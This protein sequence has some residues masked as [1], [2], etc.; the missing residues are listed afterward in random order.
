[1]R[2]PLRTTAS[3]ATPG[4][5]LST[6]APGRADLTAASRHAP[7]DHAHLRASSAR[8]IALPARAAGAARPGRCA[9]SCWGSSTAVYTIPSLALFS[10]LLPFTGLSQKTVVIG[11]VL[12][13]LTV[14]VR[15]VLTGLD[16]VPEEV[17]D[18][19]RGM[20]FAPARAA[21]A[22]RAAA[23]AARRALRPAG[24]DRL[25]RRADDGRHDRRQRR[26]RRPRSTTA[27]GTD[28][29]AEVLTA[30]VLCVVL[31]L[32]LDAVLLVAARLLVP[33]RRR[34]ARGG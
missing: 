29:N 22:G 12:Y 27:C 3:F 30:S 18:A 26:P 21:L 13:S 5:A 33:W 25:D 7:A 24:R 15:T 28:F 23:G 17:R 10:L 19:A 2:P 16:G 20:G 4:C 6:C 8:A 14:L 32:A 31:A 34:A 11:L 1:M 9:R